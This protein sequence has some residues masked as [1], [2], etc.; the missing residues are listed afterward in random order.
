MY[1]CI[2]EDLDPE[3]LNWKDEVGEKGTA[4]LT[5]RTRKTYNKL[6]IGLK[7]MEDKLMVRTEESEL[8]ICSAVGIG[9]FLT[10]NVVR[11]DLYKKLT[12]HP[13]HGASYI[14]LKG[15]EASNSILIDIYTRKS[16]TFFRFGGLV[17]QTVYLHR[18][19]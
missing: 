6:K 19:T 13:L 11:P 10:Q 1:R 16:D 12:E 14:T 7:M 9:C 18:Q 8:K 4:S 15:D 2:G 5:A 3:F 17:D